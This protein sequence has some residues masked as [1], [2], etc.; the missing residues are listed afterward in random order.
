MDRRKR[1]LIAVTALL[2]LGGQLVAGEAAAIDNASCDGLSDLSGGCPTGSLTSGGASVGAHS[3]GSNQNS[4]GWVPP[5]GWF[6]CDATW[7]PPEDA[8]LWKP[9][10]RDEFIVTGPPTPSLSDVREFYPASTTISSEPQGWALRGRPFNLIADTTPITRSGTVLGLPT[11]ISFTPTR[12]NWDYGDGTSQ[13]TD[14][15][16]TSWATSGR[17]RFTPTPTSHTYTTR[18]DFTVSLSVDY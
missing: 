18:G 2:L 13:V 7:R 6:K 15:G 10:C 3:G 5:E 9:M 14:A 17:K 12:W 4:P 8:A 1:L 16:G 11:R